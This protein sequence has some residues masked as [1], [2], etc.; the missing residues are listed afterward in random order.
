MVMKMNIEG[1]RESE[2]LK[3]K[4]FDA[5]KSDMRTAAGVC[6]RI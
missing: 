2:K 6:I 3:K 4:R 1:N 5:I